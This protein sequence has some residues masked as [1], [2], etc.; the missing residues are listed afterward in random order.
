MKRT[1]MPKAAFQFFTLFTLCIAASGQGIFDQRSDTLPLTFAPLLPVTGMD[2]APGQ[3]PAQLFTPTFNAIDFAD[4]E[5]R[6]DNISGEAFF[7][8]TV[9]ADTVLGPVIGTSEIVTILFP[10]LVTRFEF[11]RSVPL[12]PGHPYVLE[13]SQAGQ[14]RIGWGTPYLPSYAYTNGQAFHHGQPINSDLWFREG[15]VVPSLSVRPSS[16]PAGLLITASGR[17]GSTYQLQV[18]S[19]LPAKTWKT[20]HTFTFNQAETN[21]LDTSVTNFAMRFY[22]LKS[23]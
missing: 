21:I 23:L 8:V 6:N 17:V 22:T 19:E 4:F 20:I 16:N 5:I 2:L 14:P 18:T 1:S 7:V 15:A 13:L 9:H 11:P 12:T 10:P 3:Q